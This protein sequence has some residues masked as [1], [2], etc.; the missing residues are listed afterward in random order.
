M[1]RYKAYTAKKLKL[2]RRLLFF[3][4]VALLIFAAAVIAGNI[5]KARVDK[6]PKWE[7]NIAD[8][9]DEGTKAPE[10]DIVTADHDEALADVVAGCLDISGVTDAATLKER[11]NELKTAGY[12]AVSYNVFSDKG[13][14]TY[15]SPALQ[16]MVR[17]PASESLLSYEALCAGGEYGRSVG[18][19][20]SCVFSVSDS[21]EA[22]AALAGELRAAGFEEIILTGF[23]TSEPTGETAVEINAY[24]EKLREAADVDF[25]ILLS[26]EILSNSKNAP[27]IEKLFAKT[28][29]LAIDLRK[30]DAE[31]AASLT[32][33]IQGSFN[34]YML[35][36]LVEG[37]NS[38]TASAVRKALKDGGVRACQLVSAP[39][40][41][42]ED[43]SAEENEKN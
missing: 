5:L 39:E 14:V 35:R 41:P 17:L 8:T 33:S 43:T 18:L 1:K 30:V 28:E 29:F 19:R 25:G 24:A 13:T 42:P 38:Q 36:P 22:D 34:A 26:S 3:F 12:N 27:F 32:V 11:I 20:M 31:I 40:R 15:A 16:A 10:T 37:A 4:V 9:T 6:L 7:E 21:V 2:P 23:E